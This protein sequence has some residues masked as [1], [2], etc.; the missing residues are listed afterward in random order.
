MCLHTQGPV[1]VKCRDINKMPDLNQVRPV[2]EREEKHGGK[3]EDKRRKEQKKGKKKNGATSRRP[4][5]AVHGYPAG[6][7]RRPLLDT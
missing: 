2:Q 3:K 7:L 6:V 5:R 4:H 1:S